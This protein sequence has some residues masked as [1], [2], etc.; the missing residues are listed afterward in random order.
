M[1]KR[2]INR[3]NPDRKVVRQTRPLAPR[4]M[5]SVGQIKSLTEREE[6][7]FGLI[8]EGHTNEQIAD[9]M[10]LSVRTVEHNVTR[11]HLKLGTTTRT[12]LA[13]AAS[14]YGLS[15]RAVLGGG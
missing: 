9:H 4:P 6:Q 13:V 10:I 15:R 14:R 8:G 11:C 2:T 12:Q 5:P 1:T 3:K 7:V